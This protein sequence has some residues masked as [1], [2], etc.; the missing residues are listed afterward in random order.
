MQRLSESDLRNFFF[1][2]A[3]DNRA[4]QKKIVLDFSRGK[5]SAK[6]IHRYEREIDRVLAS[7][8]LLGYIEYNASKAFADKVLDYLSSTIP[9]L[10]KRSCT[11]EALELVNIMASNVADISFEDEDDQ[12]LCLDECRAYWADIIGHAKPEDVPKLH[13]WFIQQMDAIK[14]KGNEL[15][16][17]Y[18]EVLYNDF[19]DP[20]SLKWKL[21][22]IDAEIEHYESTKS[23][24]NDSVLFI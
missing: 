14:N 19:D 16:G 13:Q 7:Y 4:L 17:Y 1:Q 12:Q 5:P 15:Y 6:E 10:I 24:Q 20:A 3:E 9:P 22:R 18:E 8:D 21:E 2:L 11:M 23:D